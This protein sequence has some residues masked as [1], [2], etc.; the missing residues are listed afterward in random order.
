M[1]PVGV[2]VITNKN[3]LIY[4]NKS[5]K[6]ILNCNKKDIVKNLVTIETCISD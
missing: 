1:L 4:S 3:E 2:A 6:K 5:L